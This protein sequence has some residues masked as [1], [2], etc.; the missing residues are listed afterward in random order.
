MCLYISVSIFQVLKRETKS[1]VS[2]THNT[3]RDF[4]ARAILTMSS[5]SSTGR[6]MVSHRALGQRYVTPNVTWATVLLSTVKAHRYDRKHIS[7]ISPSFM[8]LCLSLCLSVCIGCR[9]STVTGCYTV[10]NMSHV[11]S[12]GNKKCVLFLGHSGIWI[13]QL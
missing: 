3:P 13:L 2:W 1:P 11:W 6:Y 5:R 7:H 8:C 4:S 10:V 9:C 12:K